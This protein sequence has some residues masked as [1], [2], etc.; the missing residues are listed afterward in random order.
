MLP[1]SIELLNRSYMNHSTNTVS[2]FSDFKETSNQVAQLQHR[3]V[4]DISTLP[5]S[6]CTGHTLCLLKRQY[7]EVGTWSPYWQRREHLSY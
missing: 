4:Q 7:L 5:R 3:G 1:Q 6:S 2:N